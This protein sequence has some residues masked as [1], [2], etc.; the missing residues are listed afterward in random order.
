[1]SDNRSGNWSLHELN[2]LADAMS[3]ADA[4]SM[5]E[6][7]EELMEALGAAF[8]AEAHGSP[9]V[10]FANLPQKARRVLWPLAHTIA[11]GDG[12]RMTAVMMGVELGLLLATVYRRLGREWPF[13]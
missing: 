8:H 10:S 5:F 1:M 7:D 2:A 11:G 13:R 4:A 9:A 12:E 6:W 3:T